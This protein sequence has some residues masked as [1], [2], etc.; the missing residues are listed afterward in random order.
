MKIKRKV[1][2][3]AFVPI[4]IELESE[5]EARVMKTIAGLILG[6]MGGPRGITDDIYAFLHNLGIESLRSTGSITLPDTF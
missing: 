5:E 4:V 1:E 6:D 3:P 2:E